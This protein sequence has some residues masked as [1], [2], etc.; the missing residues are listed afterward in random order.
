MNKK[1]NTAWAKQ[2]HQDNPDTDEHVYHVIEVPEKSERVYAMLVS[3][4]HTLEPVHATPRQFT[5]RAR[6]FNCHGVR[7]NRAEFEKR[8]TLSSSDP[9]EILLECIHIAIDCMYEKRCF[10]ALDEIAILD[11]AR[12]CVFADRITH[13][14]GHADWARSTSTILQRYVNL[15]AFSVD[16]R[17][18]IRAVVDSPSGKPSAY[19]AALKKLRGA[20]S[21]PPAQPEESA[22][23]EESAQPEAP[24][25]PE[26][27]TQ[28]EAPAQLWVDESQPPAQ[29]P[30]KR[31]KQQSA[32][33]MW[34]L[35][36]I[37][38]QLANTQQ[39]LACMMQQLETTM[40][41]SK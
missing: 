28:P 9:T 24:A 27:P 36:N 3:A 35:A 16:A 38:L 12:W 32:S 11:N 19:R 8:Y 1:S 37:Q 33:A 22:Q 14:N 29:R 26:T 5:Y 10:V 40:Q 17:A 31:R 25:Q 6:K 34:Q 4:G 23:S 39:Q 18:A 13:M 2:F 21:V 20:L 7:A 30:T 15:S 41:Y